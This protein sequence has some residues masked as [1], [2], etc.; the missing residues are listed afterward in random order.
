MPNDIAKIIRELVQYP[1][2]EEWFE[3]KENWYQADGIGEYFCEKPKS[4]KDI[5]EYLGFKERKSTARYLK[6]LFAE[7]GLHQRRRI[8]FR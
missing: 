1:T 4:T 7:I 3:F 8:R 6:K 5:T 2:E